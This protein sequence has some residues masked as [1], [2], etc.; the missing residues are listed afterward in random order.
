MKPGV[1]QIH[2]IDLKAPYE[3]GAC[4]VLTAA[5]RNR[6]SSFRATADGERWITCR[7]ALRRILSDLIDV[8]PERVPI[9]ENLYGKPLLEPAD[10]SPG[11]NLSH[12]RDLAL[13]AVRKE[14]PV[15]IDV[16]ELV[17]AA[18][19]V[20][21]ETS[22]CHADEIAAL[23]PHGNGREVALLDLWTAK[24]ALLKGL[25]TGFSIPPETIRLHEA[26]GWLTTTGA[27]PLDRFKV[28]RLEGPGLRDHRAALAVDGGPYV[29][30][31]LPQ[32]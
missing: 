3:P 21:C 30:E 5:E 10:Q 28:I 8:P 12:C 18:D 16:E 2:H 22:F 23:P 6:A 19:L 7:A 11:F 9:V 14:G 29:I 25:G 32:P 15:G 1:I 27:G 20:E 17:R 4:G 24:E 26:G 31:H 13:I